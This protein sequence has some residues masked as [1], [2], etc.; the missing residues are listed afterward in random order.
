MGSYH[1]EPVDQVMPMTARNVMK[2]PFVT[3]AIILLLVATPLCAQQ[4]APGNAALPAGKRVLIISIDGMRPDVLLRAKAPNLRALTQ[5]GSF[6][7]W[8]ESTDLAITLPTHVSMLTGVTPDKHHITWN[9]DRK[10][11][12]GALKVPTLFDLAKQAGY[13]NSMIVGKNKLCLLARPG[14]VD[15]LKALQGSQE[16][17]LSIARRAVEVL[18]KQRP[19]VMFVHFPAPDT[20]GHSLGWGSPEQVAVVDK[21]DQ[22]IGIL[23]DTLREQGGR[24]QSLVLVTAD[25]GGSGRSHGE[26]VPFSRYIPW[27]AVGPGIKENYDLTLEP[28]LAVHVEDVFATALYFL[29]I[30]IPAN[31]DGKP[32]VAIFAKPEKKSRAARERVR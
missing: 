21:I 2:T 7:F 10:M 1:P 17:S 30:P 28:D 11:D 6:T 29:G 16:D 18:R 27:I 4:P 19:H 22:G 14:V 5:H 20:V 32:V 31:A 23:L 8:A 12:A 15:C 25:H 9:H 13:T 3:I 24:E 26:K